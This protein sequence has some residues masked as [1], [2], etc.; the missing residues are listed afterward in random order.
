MTK[1]LLCIYYEMDMSCVEE[2]K[3]YFSC[4]VTSHRAVL[5]ERV[6]Q[7]YFSL[8]TCEKTVISVLLSSLRLVR[9]NFYSICST[10]HNA[11]KLL[12]KIK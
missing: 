12:G 8:Y 3:L 7:L 2:M 11:F 1:Y 4:M 10:C 5:L 9:A 6:H